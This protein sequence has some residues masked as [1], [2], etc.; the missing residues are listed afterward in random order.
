MDT[1]PGNGMGA[2]L[3]FQPQHQAQ[4]SQMQGIEPIKEPFDRRST[5]AP[6]ECQKQQGGKLAET[7]AG[8][9]GKGAQRQAAGLL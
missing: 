2:R 5:A 7:I 8:F 6:V 4:Q 1:R 9:G 3:S